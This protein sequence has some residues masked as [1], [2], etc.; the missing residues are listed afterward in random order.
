MNNYYS[1]LQKF[2]HSPM[3]IRGRRDE[4][5]TVVSEDPLEDFKRR[6]EERRKTQLEFICSK[7]PSK[8]LPSIGPAPPGRSES[9][10][11]KSSIQRPRKYCSVAVSCKSSLLK[12]MKPVGLL[13][14][15]SKLSSPEG[16]VKVPK[17]GLYVGSLSKNSAKGGAIVAKNG[18]TEK[19]LTSNSIGGREDST[20]GKNGTC[21]DKER[22]T[23]NCSEVKVHVVTDSVKSSPQ[24][25]LCQRSSSSENPKCCDDK[26]S[27][28]AGCTSSLSS[29][30]K[31]QVFERGIGQYVLDQNGI[32]VAGTKQSDKESVSTSLKTKR[33]IVNG[34]VCYLVPAKLFINKM[35][36]TIQDQLPSKVSQSFAT[37]S[38]S[39]KKKTS[40]ALA[41]IQT[42]TRG[43]QHGNGQSGS[44]QR[45]NQDKP[46]V[47]SYPKLKVSSFA[48][49]K[50][51]LHVQKG[52]HWLIDDPIVSQCLSAP[53]S[54]P[55][56]TDKVVGYQ[57]R[58]CT[59][60]PPHYTSTS[61][62]K[63]SHP[64]RSCLHISRLHKSN[65]DSKCIGQ[66]EGK[67]QS[68][69]EKSSVAGV[70]SK[71]S[72]VSGCKRKTS[73]KD[74]T[75]HFVINASKAGTFIFADEKS[76]Q[77]DHFL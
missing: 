19:N 67:S 75:L 71:V 58:V 29:A 59:R 51:Q 68:S 2:P 15:N 49:L 18:D 44:H 42:S 5:K 69:Q 34:E 30:S 32:K 45:Q 37:L 76:F 77:G 36:K 46:R 7:S 24:S 17:V 72:D 20:S 56:L 73:S 61:N 4:C 54:T 47:R 63:H 28:N 9:E 31:S 21:C 25:L 55:E 12:M 38:A 64:A 23:E 3:Q 48:H 53:K 65:G 35:Q 74:L 70:E 8:L 62:V 52:C 10:N 27:P 33:F 40:R 1:I 16:T 43:S 14:P 57:R 39:L 22:K 6:R 60:L 50:S 66:I 13:I 26:D 41:A 11:Q